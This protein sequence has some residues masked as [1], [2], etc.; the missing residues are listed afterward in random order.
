M[1]FEIIQYS[2]VSLVFISIVHY[3]ISHLT[4]NLT[5]PQVRDI[6]TSTNQQYEAI[7]NKLEN[8]KKNESRNRPGS[9]EMK[10]DLKEYLKS[11]NDA[12]QPQKNVRHSD[13]GSPDFSS[14]AM[15]VQQ[16]SGNENQS[17]L[18]YDSSDSVFGNYDGD[19]YSSY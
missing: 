17:L 9:G 13:V 3:L 2:I 4:D 8:S 6:V 19:A 12:N 1:I 10:D 18:T 7:I 16:P 14:S 5:T 15:P 11:L